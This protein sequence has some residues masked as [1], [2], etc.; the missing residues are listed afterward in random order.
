MSSFRHYRSVSKNWMGDTFS[1]AWVI[2]RRPSSSTLSWL[3]WEGGVG[4]S[5]L[6]GGGCSW[7]FFLFPRVRGRGV[8][9]RALLLFGV[10]VVA[11]FPW[12]VSGYCAEERSVHGLSS[13]RGGMF[14]EYYAE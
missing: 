1:V 14:S 11:V 6:R 10:L 5:P 12:Y 2:P 4:R 13:W 9:F 8:V 7:K 3:C